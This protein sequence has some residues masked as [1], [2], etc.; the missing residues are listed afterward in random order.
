MKSL[1]FEVRSARFALSRRAPETTLD[2]SMLLVVWLCKLLGLEHALQGGHKVFKPKLREVFEM[3][4][5]DEE[6]VV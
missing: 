6:P 4:N 1:T 5:K 2:V 3:K